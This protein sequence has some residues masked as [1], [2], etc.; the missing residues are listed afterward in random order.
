MNDNSEQS[1]FLK[2][3]H[4]GIIVRDM[5]TA[6]KYYDSLG[7]GP[8]ESAGHEKMIV[9]EIIYRGKPCKTKPVIR[10]MKVGGMCL[11]LLQPG[12]GDSLEKEFLEFK[13]E[14]ISHIAFEVPEIDKAINYMV[15][16]GFEVIFQVKL[17][18][19]GGGAYFNT[20]KVGG[21]LIELLQAFPAE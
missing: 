2:M 20:D 3:H 5:D 13:G 1:P 15:N 4:A 18:Q 8:I 19:G 9:A 11:E 16:K 7:L 17:E 21:V 10:M 14:G 6:I 12:E